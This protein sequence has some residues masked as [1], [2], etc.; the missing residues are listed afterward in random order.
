MPLALFPFTFS[1]RGEVWGKREDEWLG[2]DVEARSGLTQR[3]IPSFHVI[4]SEAKNL[5]AFLST[6]IL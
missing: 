6:F 2:W 4:L 3:G 1:H 5:E